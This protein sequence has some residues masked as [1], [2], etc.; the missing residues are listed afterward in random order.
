MNIINDIQSNYQCG[1]VKLFRSLKNKGWYKKSDFVH[2]WIH[3]LIKASHKQTEIWFNGKSIELK[4][5]QFVTGRTILHNETGIQESKIERILTYFEKIEHQI[6]Q[7]KTTKNRLI[8]IVS[9][10]QYQQTEQQTE[11]QLNN[12]RTTT[13]QQLN[14]YKNVK[15]NKNEKNIKEIVIP[16]FSEFKIYALQNQFNTDLHKLELK[17]KSWIES[18]WVDGK[19]NKIKNWKSKLL[20]TLPYLINENIK[21][22]G[23]KPKLAQ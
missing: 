2:L 13:E 21:Q 4:A 1:Y 8:S 22:T 9:W 23:Q 11:Q 6:E 3:I 19:G 7:Q 18:G 15:N 5:G 16:E 10:E 14:T 20:N 12:K 17:Y